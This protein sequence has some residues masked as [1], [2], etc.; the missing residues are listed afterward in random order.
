MLYYHNAKFLT[1]STALPVADNLLVHQNKI[2]GVNVPA[3]ISAQVIDLQ[4]QTVIPGFIDAHIHIWKVGDLLTYMLDLRGVRSKSAMLDAIADFA[5]KF[6]HRPWILARGFNEALFEESQIPTRHDLDQ[7]LPDRPCQIIRTCAHIA[8]LNTKA[9]E[10]CG[11]TF[12]TTPPPGGEIRLD[13]HGIPNGIITETALG[14]AKKYIPD[15][16]PDAYREMILAAQDALLEKGI[17]SATDPAVMP[18]LMAV[19]HAMNKAG[20]LKI[21]INAVPIRVPDGAIEALPLPELF[22]SDYLTVNT[23]KFFSDGGISGKTAA[24]KTAYKNTNE[25]GVLRL[26]P[27]FFEQLALESQSAGFKIATHAIGDAAIEMVV[28]VY[29]KIQKSN[30]KGLRHRIEHLGLPEAEHLAQMRDMGTFCVSQP[31]FL[32][33]LGV[34]FRQYLPDEYLQRIYPYRT[35]LDAGISLAFSSDA[36][37]VKDFDPRTGIRNAVERKDHSGVAIALDEQI[38]PAEALHA[39]TRTAAE[40]NGDAL[41]GILEVGRWA[42]MVFDFRNEM[43]IK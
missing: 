34:N 1:Q 39:Y 41:T 12:Q 40:A 5:R 14:L 8:I 32:Y 2:I 31:I 9:L 35:I 3:P 16:S 27:A 17:T 33:E 18:D 7:V 42:D 37:V 23:V 43:D 26:N 20:E 21:R 4:G 19:Y 29:E 15:P 36:P 10:I 25:H 28:G 11:I 6:P 38:T 30:V 24:V 13:T 22:Q